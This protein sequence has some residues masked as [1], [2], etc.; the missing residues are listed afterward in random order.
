MTVVLLDSR[1]L[2]FRQFGNE[3][4]R[5]REAY[6]HSHGCNFV[7]ATAKTIK[8]NPNP[9]S[10]SQGST[11]LLAK[12]RPKIVHVPAACAAST[13]NAHGYSSNRPAEVWGL[14]GS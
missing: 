4:R 13:E 7:R 2:E 8:S 9:N 12:D 6:S 14:P 3:L 11:F 5:F 1:T 10:A